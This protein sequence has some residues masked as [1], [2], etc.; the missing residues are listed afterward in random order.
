MEDVTA[1]VKSVICFN[2]KLVFEQT[3][4]QQNSINL[5]RDWTGRLLSNFYKKE[6]LLRKIRKK[7]R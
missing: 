6:A 2:S 3:R 1:L 4:Q 7:H 5:S